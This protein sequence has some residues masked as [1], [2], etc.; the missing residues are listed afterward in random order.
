MPAFTLHGA[1]GST[2]TGRVRLT[3]A[4]GGF[5]DYKLA[6]INLQKGEQK[7]RKPTSP[8]SHV[9]TPSRTVGTVYE[10]TPLG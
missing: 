9:L 7:V 4:E 5:A 1:R 3:L 6:L 10:E 8:H 2:N